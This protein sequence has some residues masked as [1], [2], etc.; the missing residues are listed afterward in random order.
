MKRNGEK[1]AVEAE[2]QDTEF[3][4]KTPRQNGLCADGRDC[5]HGRP[6]IAVLGWDVRSYRLSLRENKA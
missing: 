6:E 3:A 4:T 2:N 1:R 5:H